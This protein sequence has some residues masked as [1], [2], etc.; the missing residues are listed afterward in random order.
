MEEL[1][2]ELVN[3]QH[4]LEGLHSQVLYAY[5]GTSGHAWN[6]RLVTRRPQLSDVIVD[7][8]DDSATEE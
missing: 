5:R 7:D 3:L 2:Q 6:R 4:A 8:D 1:Q